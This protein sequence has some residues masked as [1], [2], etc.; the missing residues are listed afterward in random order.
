MSEI[1]YSCESLK[2]FNCIE[3]KEMIFHLARYLFPEGILENGLFKRGIDR[4]AA[5][6]RHLKVNKLTGQ[7][8]Y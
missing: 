1:F 6:F 4:K 5:K 7:T 8:I 3:T 2:L